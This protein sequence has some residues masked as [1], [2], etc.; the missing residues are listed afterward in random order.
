MLKI[1]LIATSLIFFVGCG[2]DNI[3]NGIN[4]EHTR[5]SNN[6]AN[7]H[8]YNTNSPYV[9][10]LEE[11]VLINDKENSCT[12]SKL[13][14]LGQQS[15]TITKDMIMQRL[16]VSHDWMGQRFSQMLD[17]FSNKMI[18]DLF[19]ATTAIVIDDDII[20]AYYWAVTGAIYL[21]PRYLWQTS[22]EKETIT[23][24]EDYRSDFSNGLLFDEG[25]FFRLNGQS[26][27]TFDKNNRTTFEA[28]L[29]LAGLL[30]HELTHA[31]DFIPPSMISSLDNRLS[32]IENI[33]N[34]G[35]NRTSEQ[36]YTISPLTS[37]ILTG[38]GQV[39]FQ[40]D[41]PTPEQKQITGL[42]AGNLFDDDNA[43]AMYAYATRYE[44]TA[45]LMQEVMMKYFYNVDG[46]QIFITPD[47]YEKNN[48]IDWGIKNPV[49][50]ETVLPRAIFVANRTLPRNGGWDAELHG[51]ADGPAL[52]ATAPVDSN[53]NISR[54]LHVD[55]K[56]FQKFKPV[57]F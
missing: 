40:G 53:A 38:L 28:E 25:T 20:P 4:S 1:I 11:C 18:Y 22:N 54:R 39:L 56:E 36:L 52:L 27:Y 34:I 49:L 5:K 41:T 15:T 6:F 35:A 9:K 45:M 31:N 43:D 57:S 16:L 42:E 32:I 26:I 44:D 12:L 46:Y 21:D 48:K 7:V 50:K 29:S 14:I 37:S 51:I 19:R 3:K 47:E 8:V 2:R 24:R 23:K 17:R 55:R 30:Y 13:P 10:V 33:L